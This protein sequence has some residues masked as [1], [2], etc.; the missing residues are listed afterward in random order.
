MPAVKHGPR[1]KGETVGT[2]IDA[3]YAIAVTILALEIP[4]S[5]PGGT[6]DI[7]A[8]ADV[9]TEYAVAFVLLFAFWLQHRRI[10][11]L[12]DEVERVGLWMNAAV[13]LLVCLVPRA[14]TLVFHH[15]DDVTLAALIGGAGWTTAEAVDLFY[16]LVVVCIDLGILGLMHLHRPTVASEELQHLHR[17]KTTTSIVLVLVVLLSFL[18]PFENRYFLLVIPVVLFM[19]NELSRGLERLLRRT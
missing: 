15:A 16:V 4:G 11:N 6:F 5:E 14:T 8:L 12:A 10:N 1:L 18:L 13:L 2:F 3:I 7:A 17:T 9:L 19:E